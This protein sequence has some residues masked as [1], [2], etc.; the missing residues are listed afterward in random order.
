MNNILRWISLAFFVLVGLTLQAQHFDSLQIYATSKVQVA[1]K[2]FQPL[3]SKA[4]RFGISSDSQVDQVTFFEAVNKY[5]LGNWNYLSDTSSLLKLEYGATIFNSN[6]YS[7]VVI[8]QAYAQLKY[9]SFIV[10]AGR[11]RD[12]WDDLNPE[13]SVGSLGTSGNALPIPKI[14]AV[15]NDYV[16]VPL[17]KGRLQFKGMMSHGWMGKDRFMESWLHEKSFYGRLNLSRVKLYGGVQHYAEWGGKRPADDVYLDRS[18]KGFFNVLLVAEANDGSL[19]LEDELNGFRPNRA[20]DQRGLIEFG[21][22]IEFEN[23]GLQIY[24]Q[25]P[26]ESG[27]G[28]DVRNIDRIL[29]V[30]ISP[31]ANISLRDI[32]LEFIH[33]KQME[34][35]GKELQSYYNNG[36]M[37]TGWE[38]QGMV[39]GTPIITNRTEGANYLPIT[40]FNWKASDPIPGNSNIINNRLIGANLGTRWRINQYISIRTK[41]TPVINY[42]ARNFIHLYG[43]G[44]G[45]FQCY[46]LFEGKYQRD[47]WGLMFSLAGDFGK[48]Y[49]NFGS[50]LGFAYSF[51]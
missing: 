26:F 45:V 29:G 27:T 37:K 11:H 15:I 6:A 8:Q 46:S 17:T 31:K 40:P 36:P 42:G 44:K 7:R 41:V 34:E 1:S 32:L 4:N 12:L 23:F 30:R 16:N 19:P 2:N 39:I 35:Y 49:N 47:N 14:S 38:Y 28:I 18:L 51:R 3:W 9:K 10:R 13:L 48:L 25:T 43:G 5:Y 20:G 22:E 24:N 33:T 21:A 50:G